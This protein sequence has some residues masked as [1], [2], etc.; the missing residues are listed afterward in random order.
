M[1]AL[2]EGVHRSLWKQTALSP[3]PT[4]ALTGSLS[5]DVVIIGGGITGLS[6]ALHLGELGVSACVLEA[7]EPAW[8]A[9]GRNG[10][11]VIPGIKHDPKDL[12]D[13]HG[14]AVA[15]PLIEMVGTAADT[16]FDVIERYQIE[17]EA[18][19]GGWVQ[20]AHSAQALDSVLER[21][22]QWI[23]RGAPAGILN[24]SEIAARLGTDKFLGGWIDRRAGSVQPLS[25]TRGLLRAAL[26][27]GARVHSNSRVVSLER[28]GQQWVATTESGARVQAAHAIIATNGYTD[29]L[30]PGLRETVIAANSFIVATAPL[31]PKVGQYILPGREVASDSRR[32]LIYFR[33]DS[34]GRFILGGRGHFPE[35]T[36]EADWRHLVRSAHLLY[37]QL[38]DVP[39]EYRWAG[40][41]ALTRDSVPHIHEPSPNLRIVLGYNGR[42]VALATQMGRYLSR[43]ITKGEKLPYPT[44]AIEP[45]PLHGLKRLYIGLAVAYYGLCDRIGR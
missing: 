13:R 18:V 17:C 39:F 12:L 21:A 36:S 5:T 22:R 6:T 19:R 15:E 26:S 1:K 7:Q 24:R 37:P 4:E 27:V 32:L 23:D 2:N 41:I 38:K 33:R 9:S 20:P 40:R 42:G 45:I 14:S 16:V 8:G 30:W 35:P 3:A 43:A 28:A 10:G 25:Y 44:S 29:G 34:Q 11:Q 31:S